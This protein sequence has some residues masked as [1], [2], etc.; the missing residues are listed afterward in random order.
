M[1]RVTVNDATRRELARAR[2]IVEICDSSGKVIGMFQPSE[3]S[4]QWEPSPLD[5]SE[6]QRLLA[7]PAG[8]KLSEI[9]TDLD[10]RP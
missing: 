4:R 3:V 6:R 8:R 5:E 2:S 10:G 7:A 1:Q 9:I